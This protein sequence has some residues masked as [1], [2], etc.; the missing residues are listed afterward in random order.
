MKA[1]VELVFVV[2]DVGSEIGVAAIGFLQRTIDIVAIGGGAKQ[3]LLTILIVL[4]RRTLGRRQTA[5]V[6]VALAA[7]EFDG[8]CD[9]IGTALDQRAFREESVMP[10]IE[11][12]E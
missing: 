2:G 1:A 11:R 4:D 9:L 8:S 5:L 12:G 6:D 7:Q 3:R 10:D